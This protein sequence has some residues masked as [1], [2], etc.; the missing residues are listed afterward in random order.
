MDNS[1]W[2]LANDGKFAASVCSQDWPRT[3][4]QELSAESASANRGQQI[5]HVEMILADVK[6]HSPA[7][8]V[9]VPRLV[10]PVCCAMIKVF[11]S[12]HSI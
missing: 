10:V 9:N 12:P 4:I 5:V 2:S 11:F 8:R 1:A 3:V 6:A 7:E